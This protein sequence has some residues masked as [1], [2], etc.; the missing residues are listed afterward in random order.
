MGNGCGPGRKRRGTVSGFG[1]S[2]PG[3]D[4]RFG[5]AEPG[6]EEPAVPVR[7]D[8]RS[9]APNLLSASS[10]P[11]PKTEDA[12]R[13]PGRPRLARRVSLDLE[14]DYFKPAGIPMRD[15][16]MVSLT[17]E[18]TEALRLSDLEDLEQEDAAKRMGVSRRTFWRELQ[19]ARKKTA[20]ALVNGKAIKIE[21]A[22]DKPGA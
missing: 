13:G 21:R 15:L 16:E 17:L 20:D 12:F 22:C 1:S 10:G 2:V 3:Q 18:E 8:R 6:H 9:F 11:R 19:S 4:P 14:A 5:K 7:K